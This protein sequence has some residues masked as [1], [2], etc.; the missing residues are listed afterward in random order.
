M[1]A[2]NRGILVPDGKEPLRRL[3]FGR[4]YREQEKRRAYLL[5][6]I[7]AQQNDPKAGN[8]QSAVI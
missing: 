8:P 5:S 3:I 1:T 2:H 6:V 7:E 4:D